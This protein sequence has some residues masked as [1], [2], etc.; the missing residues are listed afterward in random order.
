MANLRGK[1][2]NWK[3]RRNWPRKR[4]F[5]GRGNKI[6]APQKGK[7]RGNEKENEIKNKKWP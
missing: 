6:D 4:K 2:A 3:R 7:S 5:I 1:A